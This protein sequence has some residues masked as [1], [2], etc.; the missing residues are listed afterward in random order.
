MQVKTWWRINRWLLLSLVLVGAAVYTGLSV[1]AQ[2]AAAATAPTAT[3]PVFVL[4]QALPQDTQITAA[5]LAEVQYP[6]KLVPP[7]VLTTAPV[8][9][10][11]NEALS[12]G[13]PLV[14]QNVFSPATSEQVS[15]H[16]PKG[17][18]AMDLSLAPASTVDGIIAPGD[19]VTLLATTGL[20]AQT[21]PMTE[22]FLRH[23]L[24]L[25]VNGS[26]TTGGSPGSSEALILAVTPLQAEGIQYAQV[27]GS[28]SVLLERP[29][30]HSGS[31]RPYGPSW[32]TPP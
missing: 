7:G 1:V 31:V 20:T 25:A 22:V 28:L 2:H 5:D 26:L 11:T 19:H 14:A 3:A 18:V 9:L 4:K 10:W 21:K 30:D 12:P 29:G 8:G 6:A 32:P 24:V 23:V 27:A 17:D 15:V 16:I 13:V